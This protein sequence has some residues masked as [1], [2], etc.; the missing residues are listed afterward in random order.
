VPGSDVPLVQIPALP[1]PEPTTPVAT[2]PVAPPPPVAE[3]AAPAPDLLVNHLV[4]VGNAQQVISVTASGYGTSFATFQAFTKTADGWTQTFGPWSTRIGTNGFAASGAKHEGDG[5]TPSGAYGFTFFFGINANPGVKYEYRHIG[6]DEIVW[7]DDSNSP[8]Y[9]NWVDTSAAGA[10]PGNGP[11]PMN[12]A[13]SY[14]Y[15]AV[16][17]YN[18]SARTPGLGSAIFL[19]Q[20]SSSAGSTAG[21]V[22]LPQDELL[23]VLRWLDPATA[24]VIVMGTMAA[25]TQ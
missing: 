21:C 16:I 22:S 14:D 12:N 13:P 23:A 15:G 8:N 7:N 4:G 1:T 10:V 3:K 19:H 9:N 5:K 17:A 25:V 18:T 20:Y 24:P 2:T 6:G 11:E